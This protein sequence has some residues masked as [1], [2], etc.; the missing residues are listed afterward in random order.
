MIEL[1]NLSD[2]EHDNAM[3]TNRNIKIRGGVWDKL[4]QFG[5]FKF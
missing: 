3:N 4:D 1:S 5:Y 2:L